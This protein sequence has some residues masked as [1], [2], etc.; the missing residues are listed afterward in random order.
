MIKKRKNFY[1]FITF[2]F[3]GLY[4]NFVKKQKV[5][6]KN[7][8]S[9]KTTFLKGTFFRKII[10]RFFRLISQYSGSILTYLEKS[11]FQKSGLPGI[12]VFV[13]DFF[14]EKK[15]FRN[16]RRNFGEKKILE[17]SRLPKYVFPE[18]HFFK[19]DFF[20]EIIR[21]SQI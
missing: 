18:D 13:I 6:C 15:F 4:R 17:K 2:I 10:L 20:P 14:P 9:R 8:Y 7:T 11:P 5:N 1:K 19:M 21:I 16:F 12:R 3:S